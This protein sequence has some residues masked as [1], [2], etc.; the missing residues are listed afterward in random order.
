MQAHEKTLSYIYSMFS[1]HLHVVLFAPNTCRESCNCLE[2]FDDLIYRCTWVCTFAFL[3]ACLEAGA[4]NILAKLT[5][6]PEG[7]LRLNGIWGLMVR[8]PL[9]HL[10]FS[11]I[12]VIPMQSLYFIFNGSMK[13]WRGYLRVLDMV[14]NLSTTV[15]INIHV[16]QMVLQ[17]LKKLKQLV[18]LM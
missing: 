7:N 13:I 11:Q 8:R 17:N 15:V 12:S 14:Y 9:T 3:Q 18:I 1:F 4:I 16:F 5:S 6:R 2:R 10:Y